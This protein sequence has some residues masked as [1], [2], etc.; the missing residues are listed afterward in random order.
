MPAEARHEWDDLADQV[1]GHR[2]AYYVRDAPSISDGEFD[3]LMHRL[4]ALEEAH[5]GLRVPDSP[6]QTVG[7]TFSTEF[8]AVDHLERMLSLDNV[9]STDEPHGV[10]GP[11]RAR[12]RRRRLALAVRA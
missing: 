12:R 8:G 1:R 3:A 9:F 2:F 10:G 11:G 4:E 7:G 6:T 5:P